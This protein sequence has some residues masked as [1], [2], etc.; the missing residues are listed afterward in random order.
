MQDPDLIAIFVAPL[1]LAGIPYLVSGSVATAIYGEP[2]NTL[3]IDLA[4][5]PL[6]SQIEQFPFLFPDANFYLPPVDVIALECRRTARGHFNII[7]HP[8]G[9]KADIYPS[10]NHLI[11][12]GR[13]DINNACSRPAEKSPSPR[14]NTSSFTNSI[15]TA[16]AA[17]K[18]T[19]ETSPE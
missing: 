14:P 16:K 9:L 4:V 8:T 10:Q 15:F 7:H 5:F 11:S 1:E 2:R 3:D 17:I 18:N 12:A 19:S 13:W 6:S